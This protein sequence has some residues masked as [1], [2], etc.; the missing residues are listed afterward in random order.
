[1]LGLTAIGIDNGCW[2]SAA[3]TVK[4]SW[5]ALSICVSDTC[6]KPGGG[7]DIKARYNL[8]VHA[9][10]T[11]QLT[12]L[13][14]SKARPLLWKANMS[15]S[16][17]PT[18]TWVRLSWCTDFRVPCSKVR[19]CFAERLLNNEA[20]LVITVGAAYVVADPLLSLTC[21][22]RVLTQARNE[23]VE[24]SVA[25]PGVGENLGFRLR[26]ACRSS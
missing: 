5:S 2:N 17:V 22:P 19:N 13:T 12:R 14:K 11:S 16:S 24:T 18:S 6:P 15:F 26:H 7:S 25:S 20:G 10:W 3:S 21:I 4:S 9:V 23:A 1:M 8:F